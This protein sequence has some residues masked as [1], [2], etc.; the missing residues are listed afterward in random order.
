ML[1]NSSRELFVIAN[2]L[3]DLA[4]VTSLKYFRTRN[5]TS[6]NKDEDGG[7][8]PVTRADRETEMVMREHLAQVRPDDGILGEE[9]GVEESRSGL[10]WVLDPIDG[11]RGYISG[12][13]SW[14]VLISLEDENGPVLGV[15]DQ[16]YVRERFLGG[17]GVSELTRDDETT[18]LRVRKCGDISHATL[19][20]TYPEVGSE[21]ERLSFG[22]VRDQVNL[23]RY[24][25]DCY[26]YALLALGQVDLVIE[27]GLSP[28][29]ISAPI[30]VIEAAGGIVTNWQG[31]PAHKGGQVIAAGDPAVHKAALELLGS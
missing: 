30:A 11:T 12:T 6:D 15:I 20:S 3:A 5:L 4:R 8:D 18:D 13:P 31:E 29:D 9:Y 27:A 23:T 7:F 26:G 1:Q 2:E 19:L 22:K 28:Y 21:R 14:G 24:G 25:L 16:P 17:L 10:T